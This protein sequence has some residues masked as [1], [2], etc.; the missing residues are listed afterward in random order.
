MPDSRMPNTNPDYDLPG[1]DLNFDTPTPEQQRKISLPVKIY[2]ALCLA[3]GIISVPLLTLLYGFTIYAVLTRPDHAGI[4]TDPTLTLIVSIIGA[5]LSLVGS[6]GLIILGWSLIK[7]RRRNAGRWSY[8]LIAVTVGQILTEIMLEGISPELIRPCVQLVILIAL[9]ATVDP[10]LRQERELERRLGDLQDRAAAEE[11][12]LGRDIT[13]EGYI[14][15]NFFNLFWVFTVCSMIG[16]V[17]EVIW[18]MVVVDPGV[19]QDRAGL[20]YGPFS[21]IYGVGAVI[22]TVMLNRFYR[23]NPIIIFL[24]S[25]VVG[26]A[27]E[28]A[29]SLF[30]QLAFGAVAWNYS[31]AT[32][33]GIIPD[34]IAIICGGRT[35]TLF[36][37]FWGILGLVWIKI[38]L[39]HMLELINLIP[40]KWRYSLT[41][42]CAALTVVNAAMTLGALDCWYE[43]VSGVE[44]SSPVEEF[45]A[46][47]YDNEFMENRFQSMTINPRETSRVPDHEDVPVPDGDAAARGSAEAAAKA[48]TGATAITA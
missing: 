18:H 45:Y 8:A 33:F 21:P 9:S 16:L 31:G 46:V 47:Y 22:L 23:A 36:A 1:N 32:L 39:P 35:S 7:N 37:T 48:V 27:F 38:C 3:D 28:C 13:G 5:I 30:M 41:T 20:L 29:V 14:K 6:V 40:W 2:G 10:S 19:Y 17:I 44:P 15:L 42:V 25:A 26:G 4:S 34:P 12:M 11:G 43:R 24:V